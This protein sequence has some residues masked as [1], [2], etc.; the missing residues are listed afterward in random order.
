MSNSVEPT[1]TAADL[2]AIPSATL[3][4]AF[5]AVGMIIDG[6]AEVLASRAFDNCFEQGDGA[7]VVQALIQF[8]ELS[9]LLARAVQQNPASR[10]MPPALLNAVRAQRP[11]ALIQPCPVTL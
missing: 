9:P 1:I 2:G 6:S 8:T 10:Y 5:K 4:R 7:A 3:N 11:L